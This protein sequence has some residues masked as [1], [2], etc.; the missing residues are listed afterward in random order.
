MSA[1]SRSLAVIQFETD[2]TIIEANENFLNALGYRL[3]EVR[4]RHH[5]MFVEPAARD[6]DSY[7]A[8]WESLRN[9]TF[10]AAQFKRIGKN[11]KVIWIEGAY[12]P[13]LDDSGR[14]AKVV[15]FANDVTAQMDL[16]ANLKTLIDRNFG[17]ID[18]AIGLS[19]SEAGSASAAAGEMATSM[20]S[21]ATSAEELAA[22]IGEIS[23]SMAKS[24]EATDVAFGQSVAAGENTDML[25]ASVRQMNGIVELI[26]G[27]AS[28]INL[29]ALNATIEAA[30]AGEAGRGFA[31]VAGEV[32][33]LA[34]QAARAT[35]QISREI[36]GI[37]GISAKVV[38]ALGAIRGAVTTVRDNVTVTAAAVEEQSAVTRGMSAN[39]QGA[40]GAVSTVNANISEI[41]AAVHQVADAVA[42]TKQAASVLVR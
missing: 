37:Q 8:F 13:I 42:K 19:A 12:N 26:R 20:Q 22:S 17:E 15:K 4:G 7:R 38:D 28:Q 24:K 32:K 41:S 16:L 31:V 2:G 3:D 40:S 39:M 23:H 14:V 27:V 25:A 9:G 10:Q 1:I 34:V 5:S 29:L 18:T 35:D 30:R 6:S 33:N 36:S 11:G 21:V